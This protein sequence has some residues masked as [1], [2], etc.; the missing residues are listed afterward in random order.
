MAL[1]A[2]RSAGAPV[3]GSRRGVPPRR[4]GR[5]W[6][7]ARLTGSAHRSDGII[8]AEVAPAPR[9]DRRLPPHLRAV[10]GDREKSLV[11]VMHEA[12]SELSMLEVDSVAA[13]ELKEN[14]EWRLPPGHAL[15]CSRGCRQP[16]QR[17]DTSAPAA[18][19]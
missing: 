7:S 19:G 12:A 13:K 3:S 15:A 11:G 6:H 16:V 8:D 2:W 18:R 17:S 9:D 10:D 1:Q 4:F 5:T 14:G